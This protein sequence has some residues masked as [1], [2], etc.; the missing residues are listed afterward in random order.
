MTF[1]QA[2][3]SALES[4][5]GLSEEKAKEAASKVVEAGAA[6]GFAGSE[7]YWPMRLRHLPPAERDEAI[8]ERSRERNV[9]QL[10]REFG[11]SHE[12][13]YRALRG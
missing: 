2:L 4:G 12:T 8:R 5:L 13:V 10:C 7:Y 11:C 6:R 3:V 1:C 9:Q